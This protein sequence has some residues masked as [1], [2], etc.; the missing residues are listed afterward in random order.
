[1]WLA[2]QKPLTKEKK[3][4]SNSKEQQGGG[5]SQT[6]GTDVNNS[7]LIEGG[8]WDEADEDE[9]V[10]NLY[11]AEKL[12]GDVLYRQNMYSMAS[13]HYS[14]LNNAAFTTPSI[15]ITSAAS[16][17]SF[18]GATDPGKNVLADSQL[19]VRSTFHNF[20]SRNISINQ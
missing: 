12:L 18:A 10:R 11:K 9:H 8:K 5:E 20:L 16:F 7:A 1:M 14:S 17:L 4:S 3:M 13:Q 2:E 6:D 15:I 19:T